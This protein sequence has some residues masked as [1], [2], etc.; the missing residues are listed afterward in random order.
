MVLPD[1]EIY[2]CYIDMRT[3]GKGFEEYYT[4]T[5]ELGINFI[6]GRPSEIVEQTDTKNLVL[7]VEDPD[8]GRLLKIETDLVVLSCAT[9]PSSGTRQL[10]QVLRIKLDENGFFKEVHPKLRPV[11]T[12]VRG[13]YICGAAQ[14]PKDIPDSIVQAKAAA[15]FS[16]SELRKTKIKLPEYIVKAGKLNRGG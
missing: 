15:S 16:D 4:K 1:T 13:I 8:I 10:S 6:R 5:R 7:K 14:G 11:E 3:T 9:I 2:I 12:N